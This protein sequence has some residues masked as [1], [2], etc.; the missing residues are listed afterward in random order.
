MKQSS[1][2]FDGALGISR[3][4]ARKLHHK[5]MVIL[6]QAYVRQL[7]SRLDHNQIQYDSF[8]TFRRQR[9][10][11]LEQ[12]DDHCNDESA[13]GLQ[14]GYQRVA[15]TT[16]KNIYE[17]EEVVSVPQVQGRDV[18]S[19]TPTAIPG[20]VV[21]PKPVPQVQHVV[22]VLPHVE[23]VVEVV[24]PG[25]EDFSVAKPRKFASHF[26]VNWTAEDLKKRCL[27][28]TRYL[29]H[30]AEARCTLCPDPDSLCKLPM[31]AF[32]PPSAEHLKAIAAKLMVGSR[33][34][35]LTSKTY[36]DEKVIT[37][38]GSIVKDG[39]ERKRGRWDGTCLQCGQV[40]ACKKG[41]TEQIHLWNIRLDDGSV[42]CDCT[43]GCLLPVV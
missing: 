9:L 2:Q 23:N 15:S 21:K 43:V 12:Y 29:C 26:T 24:A 42:I 3:W 39:G 35:L 16:G 6:T 4:S 18:V 32:P 37:A 5:H 36:S 40:G 30:F 28:C 33:V 27:T 34:Y 22:E 31:G 11:N 14:T 8:E 17:T 7:Q 38:V 25:G 1:S 13:I 10:I 19:E 41:C 20:D